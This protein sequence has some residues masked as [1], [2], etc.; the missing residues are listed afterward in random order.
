MGF[1][2]CF[3]AGLQSG[4]IDY[5][6]RDRDPRIETDRHFALERIRRFKAVLS[7]LAAKELPEH[8]LAGEMPSP[9]SRCVPVPTCVPRE[10]LFLASHSVHH[11]AMMLLLADLLGHSAPTELGLAFST[12]VYRE[13][14]EKD[15]Q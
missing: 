6:T 7:D 3:F 1:F 12:Q 4:V 13:A 11:L 8:L 9:H 15:E 2:E 14:M 10:L 5:D